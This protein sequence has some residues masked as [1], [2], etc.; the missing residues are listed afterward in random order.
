LVRLHGGTLLFG[1]IARDMPRGSACAGGAPPQLPRRS[2][3]LFGPFAEVKG[4]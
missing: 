3:Q 4:L 2:G 1:W